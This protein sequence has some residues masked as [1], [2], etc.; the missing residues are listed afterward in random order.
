MLTSLLKESTGLLGRRFALTA[1]LPCTLLVA[2]LGIVSA[3]TWL[4]WSHSIDSWRELNGIDRSLIA[5]A[6][7]LTGAL[8]SSLAL[9]N[10][11]SLIRLYEGYWG[12]ASGRWLARMGSA[13]HRRT[14]AALAKRVPTD[15]SAFQKIHLGYPLPT[16]PEQV[17]PTALGNILRNAE[18]HPR[19]RYGIDAVMIWPRLYPVLPDRIV[20]T[21]AAARADLESLLVISV[22]GL[23]FAVLAGVEV[24]AAHGAAW[25]FAA[26]VVAGVGLFRAGYRSATRTAVLYGQQIKVAFDVYRGDLLR[27]L[28]LPLPSDPLAEFGCWQRI[29][30]LWYRN[31]PDAVEEL[32]SPHEVPAGR[33][34]PL[35][36][37][38]LCLSILFVAGGAVYLALT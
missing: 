25:L 18:L 37:V 15:P 22:L 32:P 10:T 13:H 8:L 35:G 4:G 3:G 38:G 17:M 24:V 9:R 16:Q 7:V 27:Q 12:S 30:L 31:L 20:A 5:L 6:V 36:V 33:G 26:C 11:T 21:V 19:D 1:F 29:G 2:T 34:L 14:L 23:A 28:G